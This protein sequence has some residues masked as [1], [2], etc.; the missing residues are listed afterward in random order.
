MEVRESI[1]CDGLLELNLLICARCSEVQSVVLER[2]SFGLQKTSL[3]LIL[4]VIKRAGFETVRVLGLKQLRA[5]HG[6]EHAVVA[7]GGGHRA[8]SLLDPVLTTAVALFVHGMSARELRL[9]KK[10]FFRLKV[11]QLLSA[12]LLSVRNI[13]VVFRL[14]LMPLDMPVSGK[15]E[16]RAAETFCGIFVGAFENFTFIGHRQVF[17][18]EVVGGFFAVWRSFPVLNWTFE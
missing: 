10:K 12:I 4:H 2:Q 17:V 6:L 18:E 14:H 15:F 7:V 13:S 3:V 16:I 9:G 8:V 1:F 11:L 5:Q